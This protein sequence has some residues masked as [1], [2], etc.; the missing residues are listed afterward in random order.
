MNRI[1]RIFLLLAAITVAGDELFPKD[2]WRDQVDPLASP[3]ATPGGNL[4]YF[5]GQEP[6][7]FNYYLENSY[8]SSLI[9]GFLYDSLLGGHPI[10]LEDEPGLAARWS[11]SD[12]KLTFTFWLDKRARWSDGKPITAADVKWTFDKVMESPKTGPWKVYLGRFESAEVV[13]ELSVRFKAKQVHWANLDS[14]GGF[15][16]LPKHAFEK[17]VFEDLHSKFEVVSGAYRISER[18]QG[19]SVSI[20]KRPDWWARGFERHRFK[21]NFAT[22][23]FRFLGD[24]KNAFET[25]QK[26][27]ID[28]FPVYT[29]SRW[30]KEAKG[31]RYKQGWIVKQRVVNY[32]PIGFQGFSMNMRRPQFADKQTRQAL[33]HLIDREKMNDKLMFN[34]YAMHRSYYEDLYSPEKPCPNQLTVF[35]K[36]AARKLLA[37]AGWKANAKTGIIERQG[38]PFVIKFLTRSAT[39]NRFLAIF[40]EDLLDVGIKLEIEQKEWAAWVKDMD[41]FN[42]DMTWSAWGA[43]VR[44]D[45]ESMWSSKEADRKGGNNYTGFKSAKVDELIEKQKSIFDI[46]VRHEIVRQVDKIV[47]AEYPYALL[48]YANY[49]RLLYWNKFGMPAWVLSKYGDD[50]SALAYWWID[51]DAEADLEGAMEEKEALPEKPFDVVFDKLY[52]K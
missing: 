33:A 22:I 26:G 14:C 45:P 19:I 16:I 8:S 52:K 18:K 35:D 6:S 1:I 30:I 44:K 46:N 50:Q 49:T 38:K 15:P 25:F 4:S 51:P 28:I 31:E 48:W 17:V 36:E 41:E 29:S 43:G 2:G 37:E 7:S 3:D 27:D 20:E 10:T 24:R 23:K 34:Q 40:A 42:F 5:V 21:L 13:D 11:I 12:D 9:F 39:S 47:F 32:N